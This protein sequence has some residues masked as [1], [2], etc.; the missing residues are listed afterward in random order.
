M[1]AAIEAAA[2]AATRVEVSGIEGLRLRGIDFSLRSVDF[3]HACIDFP[4][5]L[6]RSKRG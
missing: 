2:A 3:Q 1:V 6:K 4:S 5:I